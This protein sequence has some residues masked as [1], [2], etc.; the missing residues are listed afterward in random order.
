MI[1]LA[2]D[3]RS[4]AI[5][6]T[7]RRPRQRTRELS[8]LNWW[9]SSPRPELR[10][11]QWKGAKGALSRESHGKCAYCDASASAV[12][13]CDVEHY[14]PKSRYWWLALCYDNYLFACQICNQIYKGDQFP[15]Y[16]PVLSAPGVS[17]TSTAAEVQAL[18]GTFAP[19]PLD[20]H[21]VARFHRLW[22]AEQAGL[23]N[24]YLIDP[25]PY[26]AY[27]ADPDLQELSILPESSAPPDH[28]RVAA[29]SIRVYGLNRE[30]LKR[31]R[32]KD[33]QILDAGHRALLNDPG[34]P[35]LLEILGL[36]TRSERSFS[37]MAR[38]YVTR[39]WMMPL[40]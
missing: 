26:F 14:R 10:G 2:R 25:E 31:E 35:E 12:A 30:E 8:L 22:D 23:I 32:Y 4:T 27:Q 36:L 29:D 13:H 34:N 7:F 19:D 15:V 39:V 24:P 40:P 37:G 21:D 28:Q 9:I 20:A 11:S 1:P 16:G 38:Y 33:Y 5:P 3:R 6:A 17:A 18:I